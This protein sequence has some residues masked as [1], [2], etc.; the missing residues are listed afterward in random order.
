VELSP[1]KIFRLIF[2]ILLRVA[3][4][5]FLNLQLNFLSKP[6]GGFLFPKPFKLLLT[7]KNVHDLGLLC[8][9][10]ADTGGEICAFLGRGEL[11][12]FG[13]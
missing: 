7:F 4:L 2:F 8:A 3:F 13:L 5:H 9:D 1:I 11:K 6:R 12:R 10:G